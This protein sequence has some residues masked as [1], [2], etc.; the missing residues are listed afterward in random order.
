MTTPTESVG[1]KLG[2]IRGQLREVIHNMNNHT[3]KQ[4]AIGEKLSKL[5]GV[6][7]QLTKI[8]ERITSLETHRHRQ[9]GAAGFGKWLMQ[10]PIIT[11]LGLMALAI[12][13]YL[14][15]AGK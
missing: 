13:V 8:D 9:D 11:W 1:E 10:S 15:D 4:D 6:P 5:E 2:E 14:K 3:S 7:D 12:W